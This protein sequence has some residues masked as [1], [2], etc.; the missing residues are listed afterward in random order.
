M[1]GV[2]EQVQTRSNMLLAQGVG[3][4]YQREACGEHSLAPTTCPPE[5]TGRGLDNGSNLQTTTTTTTTAT[6]PAGRRRPC[7][8][9]AVGP[10]PLFASFGALCEFASDHSRSTRMVASRSISIPPTPAM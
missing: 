10:G 1:H 7:C 6:A 9:R 3:P 4:S 8:R 2:R 5:Y